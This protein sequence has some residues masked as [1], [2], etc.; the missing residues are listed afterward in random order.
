MLFV[1]CIYDCMQ[2]PKKKILKIIIYFEAGLAAAAGFAVNVS[3]VANVPPV[4]VATNLI[5]YS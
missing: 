3:D 4:I 5:G 2:H 1:C